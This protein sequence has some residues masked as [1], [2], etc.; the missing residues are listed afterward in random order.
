MLSKAA[1]A[2][3]SFGYC[4]VHLWG[5]SLRKKVFS[6]TFSGRFF[7]LF[8]CLL[9]LS[10]LGKR[11]KLKPY[12]VQIRNMFWLKSYHKGLQKWLSS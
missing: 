12:R 8:V 1:E 7:Y 2:W 11:Q 9:C 4:G 6:V 5:Q 10:L 3:R